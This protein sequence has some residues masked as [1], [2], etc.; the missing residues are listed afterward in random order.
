[1][2]AGVFVGGWA[3]EEYGPKFMYR[4]AA[5]IVLAATVGFVLALGL[6]TLFLGPVARR[7]SE[8][9]MTSSSLSRTAKKVDMEYGKKSE[10]AMN[11]RPT[12]VTL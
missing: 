5:L 3:H 10:A 11:R 7:R 6:D 4:D 1:M 12:I 2:T 8:N 9:N